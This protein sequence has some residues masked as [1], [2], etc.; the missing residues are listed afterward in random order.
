M[1]QR[2]AS[3]VI[4]KTQIKTTTRYHFTPSKMNKI[5]KREN[6]KCWWG[7]RETGTLMHSRGEMQNGAAPSRVFST[8]P[9]MTKH[10]LTLWPATPLLSISPRG[11][12]TH[13]QEETCT[14]MFTA[15]FFVIAPKCKQTKCPS[16]GDKI[17]TMGS[18]HTVGYYPAMKKDEVL[19]YVTTWVHPEA[20]Y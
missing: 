8:V 13:V 9:H 16:I 10:R 5:K 2:S 6:G 18:I 14:Q 1:K 11:M 3:S 12:K 15:M 4:R 20:L 17:K 19:K 7:C